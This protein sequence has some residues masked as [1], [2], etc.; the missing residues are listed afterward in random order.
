M[1][2]TLR[3][4][5]TTCCKCC[6]QTP[7]RP[8]PLPRSKPCSQAPHQSPRSA[9]PRTEEDSRPPP[10]SP[11]LT[12]TVPDTRI[13]RPVEMRHLSKKC[14]LVVLMLRSSSEVRTIVAKLSKQVHCEGQ[15]L[16]Q[17][18]VGTGS[19]TQ[20]QVTSSVVGNYTNA[21]AHSLK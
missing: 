8:I 5:P 15:W 12:R 7:K 20:V 11:C 18:N 1:N 3:V 10:L 17:S 14:G 16:K 21:K 6:S 2:P 4:D 13:H 19:N 9:R